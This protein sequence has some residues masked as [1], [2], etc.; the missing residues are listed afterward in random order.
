MRIAII[1]NAE[2]TKA[3]EAELSRNPDA[4]V[5][6]GAHSD[7]TVIGDAFP[8]VEGVD[9]IDSHGTY[10]YTLFGEPR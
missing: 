2:E 8:N 6:S 1:L 9:L 4:V 10:L 5:D 7:A 3:R